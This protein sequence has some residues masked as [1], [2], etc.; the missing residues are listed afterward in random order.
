MAKKNRKGVALDI[1]Q[2]SAGQKRKLN[3]LRLKLTARPLWLLDE[4]DNALD[5]E[6]KK[7][8]QQWLE[9]H[10]KQKGMIVFTNHGTP[11]IKAHHHVVIEKYAITKID[12]IASHGHTVFASTRK[13][14]YATNWKWP[15]TCQ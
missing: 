6:S 8:L 12:F 1:G 14:D 4:A 11:L 3:L 10:L 5:A 13:R 9:Q 7:T 15:G 2:L